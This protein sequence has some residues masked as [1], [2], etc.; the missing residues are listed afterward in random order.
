MARG[1]WQGAQGGRGERGN[2]AKDV[3]SFVACGGFY[4]HL[5][6]VSNNNDKSVHSPA[7][8]GALSCHVRPRNGLHKVKGPYPVPLSPALFSILATNV[9][10]GQA[11][12]LADILGFIYIVVGSQYTI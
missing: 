8:L 1:T 7:R 4:G 6:C 10:L 5:P 11:I 9:N 12:K 2:G 3:A